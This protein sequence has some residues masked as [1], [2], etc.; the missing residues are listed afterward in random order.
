MAVPPGTR[1]LV[2]CAMSIRV[3]GTKA[4]DSAGKSPPPL[5]ERSGHQDDFAL[6]DD[7]RRD[8]RSAVGRAD[9]DARRRPMSF[10]SK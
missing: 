3:N 1:R 10:N 2:R 8:E 5:I 7:A 9:E 4:L 6:A